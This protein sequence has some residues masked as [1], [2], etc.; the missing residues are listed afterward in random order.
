MG[1]KLYQGCMI[2]PF[3][4]DDKY[5]EEIE[6]EDLFGNTFKRNEFRSSAFNLLGK[7]L[8][9]EE[10]RTEKT[11][12]LQRFRLSDQGRKRCNLNQNK[13][14]K[15]LLKT[16]SRSY[17]F[18]IGEIEA[19][20]LKSGIGFLTIQIKSNFENI[21]KTLDFNA[22]NWFYKKTTIHWQKKKS[23]DA[24]EEVS[25]TI[26]KLAEDCFKLMERVFLK[27]C[28]EH[29]YNL[30]L[31]LT[32]ESHEKFTKE[33]LQKLCLQ[34]PLERGNVK[35]ESAVSYY[36]NCEYI[37]WTVAKDS[38]AV[39]TDGHEV[40]EKNM[41]FLETNFPHSVFNNYLALYLYY[42]GRRMECEKLEWIADKMDL[43]GASEITPEERQQF[44]SINTELKPM[45]EDK[46]QQI[47][48]LLR[49]TLSKECWNLSQ[50]LKNLEGYRAR[51]LKK[52]KHEV[53]LSY[54]HD[55]GQY[56]ALL[57]FNCL[58][59]RGISVFWDKKSL[60]SG[61][62]DVQLYKEIE[63]SAN[64]LV[65]LSAGCVERLQE[66]GD[67]VRKE[68]SYAFKN[69]KQVLKVAMEGVEYLTEEEKLPEEIEQLAKVHCIEA[70]VAGFDSIID[71]IVN[72]IQ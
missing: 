26:K 28:Y 46:Y 10:G 70:N 1:V 4:Y 21:E 60:R 62:F 15:Y 7:K 68:L 72:A 43:R 38:V 45:A 20:F 56:L 29:R 40:G 48:T 3:D 32:E 2:I 12:L 22:V 49:T 42:L 58:R 34:E 51:I 59:A 5:Y 19:W 30:T 35:R 23:K 6:N 44:S 17:L 8:L 9:T 31:L 66:E 24:A 37:N 41:T 69:E 54:R 61:R 53:F 14:Y 27:G 13:N 36:K 39:W 52:A 25:L 33:H 65:I 50:R 18:L 11:L 67:W 55:G 16:G 63:E 47:D 57:L 71:N 64:V